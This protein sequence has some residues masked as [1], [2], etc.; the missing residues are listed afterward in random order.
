MLV[1]CPGRNLDKNQFKRFPINLMQSIVKDL[2]VET[3]LLVMGEE[4]IAF[5]RFM[6]ERE[7]R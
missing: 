2:S 3:P 5:H 4:R 7:G 1:L 6:C